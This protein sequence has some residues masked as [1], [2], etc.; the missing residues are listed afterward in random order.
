M[1][2]SASTEVRQIPSTSIFHSISSQA[3]T[4][5]FTAC[6]KV[7]PNSK[8]SNVEY[9]LATIDSC[10]GPLLRPHQNIGSHIFPCF[11]LKGPI[12][13]SCSVFHCF[14]LRWLFC[15]SSPN[16]PLS[17]MFLDRRKGFEHRSNLYSLFI[18]PP[19][20]KWQANTSI[21]SSR[22]SNLLAKSESDKE[23]A[24]CISIV[25]IAPL[26]EQFPAW[27]PYLPWLHF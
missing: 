11:L 18:W 7:F 6:L 8:N 22:L 21:S 1:R 17:S 3:V 20:L 15:S 14:L 16:L 2:C 10:T 26:H 12:K 24:S 4:A 27:L 5:S 25:A 23:D 9:F 13:N 19:N